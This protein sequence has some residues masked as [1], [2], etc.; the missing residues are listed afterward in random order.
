[1]TNRWTKLRTVLVHFSTV[2]STNPAVTGQSVRASVRKVR[3]SIRLLHW[4]GMVRTWL[5][6]QNLRL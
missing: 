4:C 5:E 3:Q 1:M 2:G 6:I